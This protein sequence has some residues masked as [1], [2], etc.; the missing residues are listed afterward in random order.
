M[1]CTK[2]HERNCSEGSKTCR[3]RPLDGICKIAVLNSKAGRRG[4]AFSAPT[5][6]SKS[7]HTAWP[8]YA[9]LWSGVQPRLLAEASR[10]A[11]RPQRKGKD[12]HVRNRARPG[13]DPEH[14]LPYP[15]FIVFAEVAALQRHVH[16]SEKR[17][18][19]PK[20]S[21]APP[22]LRANFVRCV[23][24]GSGSIGDSELRGGGLEGL[25]ASVRSSEC[26]DYHRLGA[27]HWDESSTVDRA[28]DRG[29]GE[30]SACRELKEAA[31]LKRRL[32]MLMEE[33][34]S[35]VACSGKG[36]SRRVLRQSTAK[37][38]CNLAAEKHPRRCSTQKS[39]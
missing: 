4:R 36:D 3:Q 10:A 24:A 16:I 19:P 39:L 29:L 22:W 17:A 15:F 9:A 1:K 2:A 7:T 12:P 11:K 31:A 32:H 23:L 26:Y 20:Q 25:G 30:R 27:T 13:K 28:C 8:L 6:R 35:C 18:L 21:T 38:S 14:A 34:L 37:M 33:S 5:L